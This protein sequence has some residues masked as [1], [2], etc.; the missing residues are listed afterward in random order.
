VKRSVAGI[1]EGFST[2]AK[3]SRRVGRTKSAGKSARMRADEG[4]AIPQLGTDAARPEQPGP[5]GDQVDQQIDQIAHRNR[6][7]LK[8]NIA[9]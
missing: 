9:L 1:V 2:I 8:F 7:F 5:G 4:K 6:K 3:R